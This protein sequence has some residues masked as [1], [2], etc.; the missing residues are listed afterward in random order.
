MRKRQTK[1]CSN[2]ITK[3]A[4]NNS[5]DCCRHLRSTLK[6]DLLMNFV[7]VF[8]ASY[9]IE[10]STI[11]CLT[12]LFILFALVRRHRKSGIWND[13]KTPTYKM[14]INW[15][16]S[17]VSTDFCALYSVTKW[18]EKGWKWKSATKHAH[19]EFT[20]QY[21]PLTIFTCVRTK[22]T[23]NTADKIPFN[24]WAQCSKSLVSFCSQCRFCIS[25]SCSRHRNK[26]E[27]NTIWSMQSTKMDYGNVVAYYEKR[28]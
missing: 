7:T 12:W 15:F 14:L 16:L 19:Y 21:N 20:T 8:T 27:T 26:K 2:P 13:R 3:T 4:S 10:L 11:L 18:E 17:S 1:T 9:S 22:I 23:G 6:L 24:E 28:N 5:T 25:D